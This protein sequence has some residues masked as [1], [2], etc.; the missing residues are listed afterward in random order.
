MSVALTCYILWRPLRK[1]LLQVAPILYKPRFYQTVNRPA[2]CKQTA[3]THLINNAKIL[4]QPAIHSSFLGSAKICWWK[5]HNSKSNNNHSVFF[6]P[7]NG[8][9][10]LISSIVL[11]LSCILLT[12]P[13]KGWLWN[14]FP[15]LFISFH[16]AFYLL[17]RSVCLFS[18]FLSF[19]LY[20]IFGITNCDTACRLNVH[21]GLFFNYEFNALTKFNWTYIKY[22]MRVKRVCVRAPVYVVYCA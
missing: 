5:F 13:D 11:I 9:S 18:L 6:L 7:F 19:F 15:C 17:S 22:V 8:F 20:F 1:N 12:I 4:K 2:K 10:T 3:H 21:D 16:L 14:N